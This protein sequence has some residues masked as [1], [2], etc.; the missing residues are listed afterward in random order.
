MISIPYHLKDFDY[1]LPQAIRLY[2]LDDFA[3]CYVIG[4]NPMDLQFWPR[5]VVMILI[6]TLAAALVTSSGRLSWFVG[7][8]SVMVYLVF[9]VTLYLLPVRTH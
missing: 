3:G 6:A 9:A 2:S 4:P 5:A 8:F 7:V 1:H